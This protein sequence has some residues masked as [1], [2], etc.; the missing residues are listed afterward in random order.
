[1]DIGINEQIDTATE[2]ARKELE[3]NVVIQ[4]H[5]TYK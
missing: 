4:P 2:K 1:M 5:K 3:D